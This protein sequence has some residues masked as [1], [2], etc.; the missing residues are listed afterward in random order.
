[1]RARKGAQWFSPFVP[2]EVNF[3]YTEANSW[4]YSLYAP[5]HL[6]CLIELLGGKDSLEN[7]LDRL[8]T[9]K[10]K[11]S[12]RAQADITGLI[13]Q[14]AHGNEPSHHMAYLYNFTNKPYKTQIYVDS[15][16]QN[17]YKP[18]PH[19]LSGNEDCGQMSSWYVLS[20]IG[21]YPITPGLPVY[22]IGRPLVDK[23]KIQQENG[24]T[25]EINVLNNSKNNKFIQSIRLK[26]SVINTPFVKHEDILNGSIM[27]IE[28]GPKPSKNLSSFI[29]N[30]T[31]PNDF[32]S[33]PY[34]ETEQN[35]FEDSLLIKINSVGLNS[36]AKIFFRLDKYPF[37][38][39]KNPFY[40]HNTAEI[41]IKSLISDKIKKIEST[42]LRSKFVKKNQS[43][44]LTLK[45]KFANQYAA[46]GEN[47]LIDGVF[48]G[49]DYR[50][51]DWQGFYGKDVIAEISFQQM[52]KFSKLG[53]S[54]I[55][56]IKSWIFFPKE[57][58]IFGSID[59][60]KYEKISKIVIKKSK[61][62]DE[63]SEVRKFI[64]K[65]EKNK[66]FKHYRFIISNP[67]KCPDWHLGAGND[68]WLFL[69][70]IILE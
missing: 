30:D 63:N 28:M 67:G 36:K 64:A 10:S 40:I 51:G 6:G 49:L 16:L 68:T 33:C 61:E 20:S 12:G 38:E 70:E 5:Q 42:T 7:W 50:T 60:D 19:G 57:I 23:A 48:G 15:I 43:K 9:C 35:I 53:V 4:Q 3:N 26:D 37:Q 2:E 62:G 31:I 8:F 18:L 14:Y 65:N 11:T 56:D 45:S 39:Y 21:I 44:L 47:S 58:L 55:K 66:A 29:T 32:I 69:D 27:T 46:S 24:K 25:F 1:M 13:G 59:G 17:L 54:C 22:Q 52:K 34:I 41:S